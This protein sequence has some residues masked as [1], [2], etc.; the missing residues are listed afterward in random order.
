MKR[1]VFTTFLFFILFAKNYAFELHV[2]DQPNDDGTRLVVEWDKLPP[3]EL[4]AINPEIYDLLRSESR[5]TGERV[6]RDTSSL[7]CT[8]YLA[9]SG[10]GI[11]YA[12][13]RHC[14]NKFWHSNFSK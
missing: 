13:A 12:A 1:A 3:V 2:S 9:K 7:E 6:L 14:Q 11:Q 5:F 10:K 4:Q 8:I